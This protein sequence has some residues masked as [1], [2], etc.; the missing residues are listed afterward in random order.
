MQSRM[1]STIRAWPTSTSEIRI[2]K[3]AALMSGQLSH[4][5]KGQIEKHRFLV[6]A[7]NPVSRTRIC[8]TAHGTRHKAQTGTA[9]HFQNLDSCINAHTTHPTPFAWSRPIS[10]NSH[11]HLSQPRPLHSFSHRKAFHFFSEAIKRVSLN[12]CILISDVPNDIHPRCCFFVV[13][14]QQHYLS[15][16]ALPANS[17][18]LQA[19]GPNSTPLA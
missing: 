18:H 8:P 6:K 9:Q 19:C 4:S 16:T 11:T 2:L 12:G 7:R 13:A 10:A 14:W 1:E 17:C 15:S 5:P 3:M